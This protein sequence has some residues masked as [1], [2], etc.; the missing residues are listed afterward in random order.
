MKKSLL[1]LLILMLCLFVA[2]CSFTNGTAETESQQ[3]DHTEGKADETMQKMETAPGIEMLE[4]S[5]EVRD[6]LS[7]INLK[8]SDLPEEYQL[9]EG[10][11]REDMLKKPPLPE[12]NETVLNAVPDPT[13]VQVFYL[14]EEG[15]VPAVTEFTAGMTGYY[16]EYDFRPYV[17][18]IPV[19]EGVEVKG[20]VVLMAGGAYQFRGDYT[21]TLPTALQLR[22]YGY[23][24][25]IVDYRLSPY[26]PQEGAL[27]VARA[28]R[29]IR[30]NAD[31]YGIKPD[32]IAVMGYSAGGIQAGEF[33]MHYDED[34]VGTIL[35]E[36]YIPDELDEIPAHASADAM[37]YSFYGRLSVA[38]LDVENL[39][40]GELP[41]TFYCYGTEDPF[42]RQFEAQVELMDEVGI[43]T[44]TIV[45]QDWPHGFGGSGGWV[46]DYAAWLEKVFSQNKVEANA[47][48]SNLGT[49][50]QGTESYRNFLIDN[51][52]HS[53]Q[54]GD[55]HY[56][57][58]IPETYDGTKPYALYF[59][60]PGYGGLYFQGVVA[61]IKTEEFSFEAMKCNE[62][63][64]IVAPQL[65]DW[66]ETSAN[67]TIALLEF[68]LEQ[69]N[70]D[71][72]KVYGSGYSGG[73][74]TMSLV[75]GKRPDLFTAYLHVSSKWDGAYEPVVEQ[76]LP[77][78]LAIGK[79][80]EY[81]GSEPT[82][83]A[84]NTLYALYE[85]QG[86]NKE[87]ID[88][89]LVLDIK[90]HDYFTEQGISNEHGGGGLFAF[91]EGIMGWLFAK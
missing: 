23:Q 56:N 3:Q 60:L 67:Q 30:K 9:P 65:N 14:W 12:D 77:V 51:V 32:N 59:T 63:M 40:S 41:P 33:L 15:N 6:G 45:L 58:Y 50:T 68:F 18:A 31:I 83:K 81:Y 4:T 38:S 35:D 26:T 80:D 16:D 24:C 71:R 87:K 1:F 66:G 34:V 72:D 28:V 88:S 2:A 84:Y 52:F 91:D 55:I 11:S 39:K 57:V 10:F 89:L 86:F 76:E 75:M 73:G 61:N 17:T 79:N 53:V 49:V 42:Y 27:D 69:Y 5:Y 19:P 21:D 90:E 22:E 13:G 29:F 46:P 62:E 43:P 7:E 78:Y 64:I 54:E 20:A 36:N 8:Y 47:A 44:T 82:Q 48:D 85:Q 37:I 74:E 25:F 70:I